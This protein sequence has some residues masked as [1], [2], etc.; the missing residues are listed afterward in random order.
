MAVLL[1]VWEQPR[2]GREALTTPVLLGG[3]RTPS[4]TD[5]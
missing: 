1:G 2:D 4:D 3:S 5:M